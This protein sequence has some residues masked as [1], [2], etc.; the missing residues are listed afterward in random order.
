MN[1]TTTRSLMLATLCG[2][3]AAAPL[4]AETIV[5]LDLGTSSPDVVYAFDEAADTYV[6]STQS[7]GLVSSLGDTQTNATF[8]SFVSTA[9]VAN[10]PADASL[11]IS[12][13]Q[14]VG[15]AVVFGGSLV[16]Q[17]TEGGSFQLYDDNNILILAGELEDGVLT[18]PLGVSDAPGPSTG[19]L[20][21]VNLGTFVLPDGADDTI[22]NLLD[23]E[24]AQLSMS[25]TNVT[26]G[27]GSAVGLS[28]IDDKLQSFTADVTAQVE[29]AARDPNLL[30]EPA[31][32][33]MAMLGLL[34]MLAG[35]S[36]R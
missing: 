32:F 17:E 34:A 2:F 25:F 16:N 6:L 23:P 35:R 1:F 21:T 31:S 20:F 10:I 12:G 26:S 19:S 5:K 28:V 3:S 9:G 24:S 14:S 22:F 11:S 33:G 13:I 8:Q 30:P 4:S 7:D 15:N 18:G 29:A 36:R 27:D